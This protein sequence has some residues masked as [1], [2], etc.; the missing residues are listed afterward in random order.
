MAV[1]PSGAIVSELLKISGQICLDLD[2]RV[3]IL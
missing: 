1:D 3:S 2:S